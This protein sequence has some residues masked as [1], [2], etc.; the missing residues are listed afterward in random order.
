MEF[1]SFFESATG[2]AP[3]P[4]QRRVAIEGFPDLIEAPTA[5]GKT[6]A[7]VVCCPTAFRVRPTIRFWRLYH[8]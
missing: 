2:F 8:R 5:A 7:V 6:E 1:D 4:Y 3:Y